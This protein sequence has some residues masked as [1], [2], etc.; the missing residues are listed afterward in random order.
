VRWC[1]GVG[2]V[3]LTR[4]GLW[5]VALRQ[6]RRL[7]PPGWWR[8]RPFLPVPPRDY[9]AFRALTM[10]GDADRLPDAHDVLTYLAWCRTFPVGG[11]PEHATSTRASARPLA[12]PAPIPAVAGEGPK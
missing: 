3:L 5:P 9:L 12:G 2:R 10:Y 4:P 11:R 8:H 7:A 1:L 6:V